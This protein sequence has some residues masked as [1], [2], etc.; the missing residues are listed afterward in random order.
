V[1]QKHARCP[2]GSRQEM[3][4]VAAVVALMAGGAAAQEECCLLLGQERT[5]C[6]PCT[7][8]K[9]Q[10]CQER[11]CTMHVGQRIQDPRHSQDSLL[12]VAACHGLQHECVPRLLASAEQPAAGDE[13][14]PA[15]ESIGGG[16]VGAHWL[17]VLG[18]L[19]CCAIPLFLPVYYAATSTRRRREQELHARLVHASP[20]R[21][22]GGYRRVTP[23]VRFV[24]SSAIV[25]P[26]HA[27]RG[28]AAATKFVGARVSPAAMRRAQVRSRRGERWHSSAVSSAAGTATAMD[29]A[30]GDTAA[31]EEAPGWGEGAS[32]ETTHFGG[33]IRRESRGETHCSDQSSDDAQVQGRATTCQAVQEAARRTG[34][35]AEEAAERTRA[36][37]VAEGRRAA[38][39]I[40][41]RAERDAQRTV[42]EAGAR[43]RLVEEAARAK[44][45]QLQEAAVA[46][47]ARMERAAA[48]AAVAAP[49]AAA[50]PGPAPIP[51]AAA[52][53]PAPCVR[54]KAKETLAVEKAAAEHA[55][56]CEA[57]AAANIERLCSQS[58]GCECGACT[59]EELQ[60]Q[61]APQASPRARFHGPRLR[62]TLLALAC[63][64][65]L[66]LSRRAAGRRVMRAQTWQKWLLRIA[67]AAGLRGG[68]RL[69]N[70]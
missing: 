9:P 16:D 34:Q 55:E 68:R 47:V 21:L 31:A 51:A 38:S 60:L 28:G 11:E 52:A 62:A 25:D 23:P 48:A 40:R 64:C 36:S 54:A 18:A 46:A 58:L 14:G 2:V 63:C 70:Q 43:A 66:W 22:H 45:A 37:A 30:A 57:N 49:A 17:T 3:L 56:G 39:E 4:C 50:A 35:V 69:A 26:V 65:V 44:A 15:G 53:A 33:P 10:Q 29:A 6:F 1:P 32:R 42:E 27:R 19:I 61:R 13:P 5:Y 12:V 7:D 59:E 8:Q 24:T 41:R 67:M 20:P